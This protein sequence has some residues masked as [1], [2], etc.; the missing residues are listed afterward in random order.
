M[1]QPTLEPAMRSRVKLV[2]ALSLILPMHLA[3]VVFLGVELLFVVPSF[4]ELY[5]NM[6]AVLPVPTKLVLSVS[7][8]V[9]QTVWLWA[10]LTPLVLAADTVLLVALDRAGKRGLMWSYTGALAVLAGIAIVGIYASIYLPILTVAG[11]F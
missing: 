10:V 7:S 3:L 2:I 8:F 5:A 9:R 11:D 4:A 1:K 6:G